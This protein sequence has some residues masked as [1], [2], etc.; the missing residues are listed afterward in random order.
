MSTFGNIKRFKPTTPG[1]RGKV[2]I[3]RDPKISQKK[4]LKKSLIKPKKVTS[5]RNNQGRMTVRSRAGG[6]K[7]HIRV[8]DFKRRPSDD[9]KTIHAVVK[10]IQYDPNRTAD[11][12]LL[13]SKESGEYS[14]IICPDGLK[15]GDV[16]KSS[17]NEV[18]TYNDGDYLPLKFI[19]TNKSI[20]CIELKP[21]KGAQL[22]RSAG[23]YAKLLSK[24]E[25]Y[26]IIKL[27]SGEMRKVLVNC[28]ACIGI[29][30]NPKHQNIK[31]GKAGASRW[32]GRKP[33]VR[34]VAM[35][36][37]DHPHGGG[38][39]RTSGGRHPVSPTGVP[40]KGY[41]TRSNKRTSKYI[42][43]DRRRK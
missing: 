27:R 21:L 10:D 19:P 8:I 32:R 1:V 38:E 9:N 22:A 24:D 42:V 7:R 39:G 37:V 6:H 30:S 12:A 34:G 26:A 2:V 15:I 17:L 40:T 28:R 3:I 4:K 25:K 11:I 31:L 20:F 41:K 14:Y 18:S 36:P 33:H 16:V 35:N 5:C 13:C 43:R 23:T 29:A